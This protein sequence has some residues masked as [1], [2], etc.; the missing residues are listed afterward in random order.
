MKKKLFVPLLLIVTFGFTASAASEISG[1][2]TEVY[3]LGEVVVSGDNPGVEV[4]ATQWEI[5][6]EEIEKR[7]VKTLDEALGLLP[8]VDVRSGAQGVPRVNIRGLRTRHVV[9]LLNGIPISSTSDNQFKSANI[10]TENIAKIK[11]SYGG[12]SVLYGQGGLGGVIN[13]I[14]KKGK[15]GF[16]GSIT[17]EINERGDETG[18]INLSGGTERFNGFISGSIKDSD[19]YR[20][21]EDFTVTALEDG[22]LRDNSYSERENIFANAG[23]TINDY[24]K[25]GITLEDSGGEYGS[26]PSSLTRTASDPFAK[27]P[28]YIKVKDY[29]GNSAQFSAAY[30][31]DCAFEFRAW[32]FYDESEEEKARYDG[33]DYRTFTR[34]G[35]YDTKDTSKKSGG[36]IQGI[37][38]FK[39]GGRITASFATE[40]DEFYTV[41][42]F[43]SRNNRPL[44]TPYDNKYEVDIHS[45]AL[46]YDLLLFS[47]LDL[48]L[49]YAHHWQERDLGPDDDKGSALLGARYKISDKTDVRASVSRKVRFPSLSQLYD[50][51]NGGNTALT[52]EQATNYELGFTRQLP[53]NIEADLAGYLNDVESY[54]QKN[55]AGVN[56]NN[57]EY[58]F[59]G[60]E[61]NLTKPFLKT[62]LFTLGY[63]FMDA[64][65][66]S[67]NVASSV[68]EYRPEHKI[69]VECS[70]AWSF[71][72][73][74]YASFMHVAN[75][76]YFDNTETLTQELNDYSMV[77]VK[78]EQRILKDRLYAFIGCTNLFDE[79][80]EESYGF[81]QT[82]RTA[83]VGMKLT[84]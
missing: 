63:S 61:L 30:D 83:Y 81:P 28:N 71:G 13:I 12:S 4:V 36:N 73:S 56:Q 72:L 8:G 15:K 50:A 32:I 6:A 51:N 9:L 1:E 66:K 20:L 14:T 29:E 27:N 52:T 46:E 17:G 43:S 21:S 68:L 53:W 75:Q 48:V 57:D 45:L 84:F 18:R 64:K 35:N 82:G 22:G 60:V 54:I 5:T 74:A 77:D 41:G 2:A 7:N 33:A 16:K 80:Y 65:N 31:P 59:K 44:D 39:N 78:L 11:V 23:Y 67:A 19:G 42:A 70:Y 69:T 38:N 47:K 49:G 10:A 58:R 24:W 40:Q 76:E 34:K 62:G 3:T 37:Y 25:I 26:P 79:D 55:P